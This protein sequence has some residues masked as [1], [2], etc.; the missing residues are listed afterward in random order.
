MKGSYDCRL[1][2]K[3]SI[4]QWAEAQQV[5][6]FSLGIL[7]ESTTRSCSTS[8]RSCSDSLLKTFLIKGSILPFIQ[9][10]TWPELHL[11]T[12]SITSAM[13]RSLSPS[14]LTKGIPPTVPQKNGKK[15]KGGGNKHTSLCKSSSPC[16]CSGFLW[17]GLNEV[18]PE[19][20]RNVAVGSLCA[21]QQTGAHSGAESPSDA[22]FTCHSCQAQRRRCCWVHAGWHRKTSQQ[23]RSA[24][25]GCLLSENPPLTHRHEV[26][27]LSV[28]VGMRSGPRHER[29]LSGDCRLVGKE[30][31]GRMARTLGWVGPKQSTKWIHSNINAI[32]CCGR[33]TKTIRKTFY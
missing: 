14:G 6:L 17:H 4:R 15:K 9:S 23:Q 25:T 19:R 30:L 11:L 28:R 1:A 32:L 2:L 27:V 10:T 20:G 21:A 16:Q 3:A 18:G 26:I 5:F 8:A 29:Q 7:A 31:G 12:G 24:Q 22:S 13:L 33:S